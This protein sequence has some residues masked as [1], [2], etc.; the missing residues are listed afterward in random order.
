MIRLDDHPTVRALRARP[1][2]SHAAAPPTLD[3]ADLK[4]LCLD[5]G[6]DD[7]GVVALDRPELDDQRADILAVFPR[8]RTLVSLVCRMQRE[9]I[10]SPARNIANLEFHQT[11]DAV[12]AAARLI[13]AR[14]AL[15][16]VRALN[17]PSGFPMDM[18]GFPGKVWSVSHKPVAV[19]AGLGRMG[20]HRNVI[21]PRFGSFVLLGTLLL[22]VD[23]TEQS[24]PIDYN[25]CLGCNLCV[26]ACPVGAISEDGFNFAAC[27]TH[28]YREFMGGFTDWAETVADAGSASAYRARVTDSESVS[29]W[30]SLAFGPNYKAAYC[31][32]VC[33]AGEDV[34][35]PFLAD[36]PGFIK[37]VVKPLQ[38][39]PET[40]YVQRNSDAAAHVARRFPHKTTRLVGNVLRPTTIAGFVGAMQHVFQP[41]QSQGLDARYHFRFTGRETAEC[42]VSIR[43][44]RIEIRPGPP[45]PEPAAAGAPRPLLRVTADADA[46][47]RFLRKDA[48]LVRLLLTR[49][50]R[51]RGDP[52]LLA[53]FGRCFPG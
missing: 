36:K 24:R 1:A 5:A 12:N 11:T 50:L 9:P 21:H 26:A 29:L 16:G 35:G 25:P 14:L 33:P 44:R 43:D 2:P 22:D 45:A 30:Q 52:R 7:A 40:V 38:A 18:A 37:E 6:A 20:I 23:V 17:P 42:T 49:R 10:L 34:I 3:P 39:K 4:A 15:R 19:A 13:C 8:T 53:R 28:N 51:L 48:S 27:Y 32:S 31:L 46:W 41:G 47:L